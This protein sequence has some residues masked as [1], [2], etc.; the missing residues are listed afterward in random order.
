M[1]LP[2]AV[3][4]VNSM[5]SHEE[6][7]YLCWLTAEQFQGWGAVVD[8]GPWLGSSSAALAEGLRRRASKA[9]VQSFDLF[10]WEPSYMEAAAP[11][12]LRAGEDFLPVFLEETRDY[13]P[14]IDARKQDLMDYRW[15]SGPIEIL[16][17]D[18]AKTWE[19]TNAIFKGFGPFLEPGRSRV[20]LQDFRYF[21]TYWLPLIFDS[22]PD[23]WLEVEDVDDGYTVTFTP[24]KPLAGPVGIQ[25]NYSEEAFPF[26][27]TERLLR[28]RIAREKPSKRHWYLRMLYQRSLL[29][30]ATAGAQEVR[31]ELVATGSISPTEIAC[32]EN[33]E[34]LLVPRGWQAYNR[35]DYDRAAAIARHAL[36]LAD[37]PSIHVLVLLA[38]SLL[39][40]GDYRGARG[41]FEQIL[42][43]EPEHA[44]ARI[45]C[46][47]IALT[48]E[49]HGDAATEILGVLGRCWLDEALV[50][51]A[52]NVLSQAWLPEAQGQFR[53]EAL[54]AL[55]DRLRN[56]PAFLCCLAREQ[57]KAGLIPD[58]RRNIEEALLLPASDELA[59]E[60]RA[61]WQALP[62]SDEEPSGSVAAGRLHRPE[63][64]QPSPALTHA[65]LDEVVSEVLVRAEKGSFASSESSILL[66]LQAQQ[67]LRQALEV[68]NNRFS[69]RRYIDQF[70][71]FYT[72]LGTASPRLAGATIVDLGCGSLNPLGLLFLFL[73]LGARRGIAIDLDSIHDWP[74][75]MNALADLASDMIVAPAEIVGAYPIDREQILRNIASFDLAQ[76]RAGYR[77]GI[78]PARLMQRRESVHAL[79]L[80]DGQADVVFSNAFFEHI[81]SV[82]EAVAE[83]A[84]VTRPGGIGVHIID[85]SD[86][87]RYENTGVHPLEFL[88]EVHADPLP[89]GSNRIRPAE[90][91]ALFEQH[92]FDVVEMHD[93]ER[94]GISPEL[95][96]RLV[97]PFRL[98]PDET[99]S[100]VIAKLIVRRRY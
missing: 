81:P 96:S 33:L 79:S 30:E 16:F 67:A 89:Y 93:F 77:T 86:H 85:C 60:L 95:R 63:L 50:Q 59:R 7:Q 76:M 1:A 94:T 25:T 3:E 40:A 45:G 29:E 34:H 37:P 70:E 100:V 5:L 35:A 48:E 72:Y 44:Y 47:E 23:L 61:E 24:L 80:A 18:A 84:R 31:R 98:M 26:A 62:E 64:P 22:R 75:A 54:L 74:R 15:E 68:H 43:R 52:V 69:R 38:F 10:R 88:T 13:A 90:F 91:A 9:K 78:D 66:G 4:R 56:S 36:A 57:R 51:Y 83:L 41:F 19:L 12:P 17:I 99:L 2:A 6:K 53:A 14:W 27:V 55:K 21:E 73:M 92:G 82:P 20:V 28:E 87:R 49:R 65:T 39:R 58:A 97:D 46:A 11:M 71:A 8:L 42:S 32:L